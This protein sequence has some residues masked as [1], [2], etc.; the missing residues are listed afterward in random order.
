MHIYIYYIDII[1]YINIYYIYIYIIW[2]I[3]YSNK[4]NKWHATNLEVDLFCIFKKLRASEMALFYTFLTKKIKKQKKW[5]IFKSILEFR[6]MSLATPSFWTSESIPAEFMTILVLL[7]LKMETFSIL[8][9]S[10][11]LTQVLF[12]DWQTCYSRSYLSNKILTTFLPF[13]FLV[14]KPM[15]LW[16]SYEA[17]CGPVAWNRLIDKQQT[18]VI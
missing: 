17:Y 16:P 6:L 4:T 14:Y 3:F 1:G 2:I 15:C 11:I 9:Q 8:P 5:A 13:W 12:L 10:P 7:Q 18:F